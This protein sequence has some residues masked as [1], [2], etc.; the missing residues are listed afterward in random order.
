MASEAENN[1]S[2]ADTILFGTG[3]AFSVS[4][5][6]VGGAPAAVFYL[7]PTRSCEKS[8]RERSTLFGVR[9]TPNV[10]PSLSD[11]LDFLTTSNFQGGITMFS[12]IQIAD[13]FRLQSAK[14][15]VITGCAIVKGLTGNAAFPAPTVDLKTVQTAI[16]DLSA[17]LAVQAQ[18]GMAAT[19]DNS[20]SSWLILAD[21]SSCC[22]VWMTRSVSATLRGGWL[23]GR[24]RCRI[25]YNTMRPPNSPRST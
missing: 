13:G 21:L 7:L 18:G 11:G 19:A 17:A 23:S 22:C 2:T 14:Q 9:R 10:A 1:I 6:T 12:Q 24:A 16:D 15:L 25:T 5:K 8:A 4:A 3:G 20:S